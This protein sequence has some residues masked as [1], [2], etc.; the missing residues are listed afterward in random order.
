MRQAIDVGSTQDWRGEVRRLFDLQATS[1]WNVAHSSAADRR[2]KLQRL[3]AS[4]EKHR[5]AIA[6]GIR[7][8]FGR[9]ADESELIE[10][11]PSFEEI[12]F[13]IAHL[14]EWMRPEPV[15]APLLLADTSSEIR[16]E[17]KGQVLILAPWNY[18][19]FL[20]LGPLVGAIAAGNVVIIKPSEKVP[21][22]NR[23]LGAVL[24]DA[25]A[26]DEVAMIE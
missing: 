2:K 25:F 14:S 4:L 3:R 17:P 8:D 19:V 20:T 5:A 18:P 10:I 13:A 9:V 16:Y 21:E 22:T 7:R 11:H 12:N 1:R 24:R 15:E 23:A 6:E 26:E